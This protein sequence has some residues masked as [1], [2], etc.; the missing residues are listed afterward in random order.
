MVALYRESILMFVNFARNILK[1]QLYFF[2]QKI[3]HTV[4]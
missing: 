4:I 2:P 3:R 1:Y